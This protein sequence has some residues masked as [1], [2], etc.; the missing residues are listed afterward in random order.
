M[1]EGRSVQVIDY[2]SNQQCVTPGLEDI[3]LRLNALMCHCL[4]V[5]SDP[6]LV[7]EQQVSI[8][9]NR[10][11]LMP[12][13]FADTA[14][15][16]DESFYCASRICYKFEGEEPYYWITFVLARAFCLASIY[17]PKRHLALS[18]YPYSLEASVFKELDACS[19]IGDRRPGTPAVVSGFPQALHVLWN[20]LPALDRAARMGLAGRFDLKILHEP[21]GPT[22]SLF[23]EYAQHVSVIPHS[24]LR[25]VNRDYRLIIALGSL[26]ITRAVQERIEFV[27]RHLTSPEIKSRIKSFQESFHPII[28]ISL[29]PPKRTLLNQIQDIARIVD[30]IHRQYPNAGFL[31]NGTAIPWDEV[32]EV[33]SPLD[34]ASS[35]VKEA[36]LQLKSN[37]REVDPVLVS[38]VSFCE[39]IMWSGIANFYVCHGGSMQNKIG[40]VHHVAGVTISNSKFMAS[41]AATRPIVEEGPPSYAISPSFIE[42]DD[43]S[44]YTRLELDRK[45]QNFKF[46]DI[47]GVCNQIAEYLKETLE[48]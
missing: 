29:K 6:E 14:D 40:W 37:L 20:E 26:T 15:R 18:M 23:P 45:D 39:E 42:D 35:Y 24:A 2:V 19:N 8:I 1:D 46:I 27:S 13:P 9:Q 32:N 43:E 4:K 7:W 22:V 30:H 5:N 21:F 25:Q 47:E 16:C 11:F 3:W 36:F 33:G 38:E 48:G 41:M 17:F 34:L 10:A 44:K 28:W 12:S 31:I